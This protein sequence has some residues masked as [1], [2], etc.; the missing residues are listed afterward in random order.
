MSLQLD[1]L[2]ARASRGSG[3]RSSVHP[4][5]G[6]GNGT[7]SIPLVTHKLTGVRASRTGR[8]WELPLGAPVPAHT[9]HGVFICDVSGGKDW[10]SVI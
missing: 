7:A 5:S 1:Q 6:K 3:G 8:D 2:R 10:Q 4:P 9:H